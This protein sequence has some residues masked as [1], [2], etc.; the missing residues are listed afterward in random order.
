MAKKNRPISA[1]PIRT[2]VTVAPVRLRLRK[3][4][5]GTSGLEVR[6]S[7]TTKAASSAAASVSG[8]AS[9]PSMTP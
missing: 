4:A 7:I 8:M 2:P 6:L 5:N 3:M 9:R 1:P